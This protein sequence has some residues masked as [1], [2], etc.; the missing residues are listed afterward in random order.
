MSTALV[1]TPRSGSV[2]RRYD[3][4]R[5]TRAAILR[6]FKNSPTAL[7][8]ETVEVKMNHFLENKVNPDFD[9]EFPSLIKGGEPMSLERTVDCLYSDGFLFGEPHG[10]DKEEIKFSIS[11]KGEKQLL[12]RYYK[13][14]LRLN[15]GLK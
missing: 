12:D 8:V 1:R 9:W 7:H 13:Q 10:K 11:P 14:S 6:I 4:P 3:F 5:T 2:I 15:L